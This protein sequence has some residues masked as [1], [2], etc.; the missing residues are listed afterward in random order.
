[1]LESL[2]LLAERHFGYQNWHLRVLINFDF[3][4]FIRMQVFLNLLHELKRKI[5]FPN[6]VSKY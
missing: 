6:F 5:H 2:H 1:M 4:R 3:I